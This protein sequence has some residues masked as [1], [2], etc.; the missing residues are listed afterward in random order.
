MQFL[1]DL[2]VIFLL[3]L[4]YLCHFIA[5]YFCWRKTLSVLTFAFFLLAI[6]ETKTLQA[7]DIIA[8]AVYKTMQCVDIF[9]LFRLIIFTIKIVSTRIQ[10]V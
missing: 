3:F 2:L 7:S 9:D 8:R 4:S 5:R 6:L 10:L 1:F